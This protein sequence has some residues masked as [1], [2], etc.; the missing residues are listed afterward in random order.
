[1]CVNE[2]REDFFLGKCPIKRKGCMSA[3]ENEVNKMK[4]F[5]ES[6]NFG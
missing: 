6:H 3:V 4:V 2:G 1:V 5:T